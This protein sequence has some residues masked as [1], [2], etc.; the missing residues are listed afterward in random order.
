MGGLLRKQWEGMIVRGCESNDLAS[1]L[2]LIAKSSNES[3]SV[4]LRFECPHQLPQ[5]FQLVY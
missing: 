2:P 5:S 4:V 1:S 3:N